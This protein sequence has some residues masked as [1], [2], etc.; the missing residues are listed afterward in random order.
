MGR[1]S[2]FTIL[3]PSLNH[4]KAMNGFSQRISREWPIGNS[5]NKKALVLFGFSCHYSIPKTVMHQQL[6]YSDNFFA[7]KKTT[8]HF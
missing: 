4:N 6:D 2:T 8:K 1:S 5:K 7:K 3:Q